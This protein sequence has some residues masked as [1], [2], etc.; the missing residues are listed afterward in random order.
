MIEIT[1]RESALAFLMQHINYERV[2]ATTPT[3]F[4][5][6]RMRR[7]LAELGNPQRAAPAVHIAGTKGKGSTAAL[8]AQIL[9]AAGIRAGLYT[10]PHLHALEERLVIDGQCCS[11]DRLA[12]LARQVQRAAERLGS[13]AQPTFF[14]LITAMA[15][16]Y[17][18]Q[19]E[20]E[21][22]VLEVGLG[23]RLDSTNA[24]EPVVSLITSISLDHTRQ[25]GATL[26]AIAA[27]KA[28]IIRPGVPVVVGRIAP[29]P[30]VVIA[31]RAAELRAP[32]LRLDDDFHVAQAAATPDGPPRINYWSPG[33]KSRRDHLAVG[34][35][36]GHQMLNAAVALA[37]VEVLQGCGW[38]ISDDAVRTGLAAAH[39]PAR[40]EIL[41]RRPAIV[42]DA[43]HNVA[44]A[45]ALATTLRELFPEAAR[46]KLILAISSEKDAAGIVAALA[47]HFQ[48]LLV[49]RF[50]CNPRALPPQELQ[51]V[52]ERF[53]A[54]HPKE[55]P[56]DIRAFAEPAAAWS[57]AHDGSRP[58]DLIC[59]AGSFFLASDLRPLALQ[60]IQATSTRLSLPAP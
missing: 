30:N 33:R 4:K 54:A 16:L 48:S 13:D 27:E 47:P 7:L 2:T 29:G 52:C 51:E 45:E 8:I 9:E 50:T 18:A 26:E 19:A 44:S 12:A 56:A 22:M 40:V 6:E 39:C 23:G 28:G 15:M 38:T 59:I 36:G 20:V 35:P 58:D 24:C 25:L 17:F 37:A 11:P 1:D 34:L 10:S 49:T 14:E 3:P 46:R 5:L 41:Q 53:R 31:Q 42:V 55:S 43:A 32:L 60:A 21:L 57:A